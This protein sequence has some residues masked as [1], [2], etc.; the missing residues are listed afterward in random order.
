MPK[1]EHPELP[2][3]PAEHQ[4]TLCHTRMAVQTGNPTFSEFVLFH[5]WIWVTVGILCLFNLLGN[6]AHFI[7]QSDRFVGEC[8]SSISRSCVG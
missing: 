7:H 6:D 1:G 5:L 2:V 3:W 4:P 8:L